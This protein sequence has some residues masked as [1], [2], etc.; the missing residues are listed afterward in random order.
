MLSGLLLGFG[1]GKCGFGTECSV[2]APES[3]FSKPAFYTKRGVPHSTFMMFRGLLPLQGFMVAIVVFNLFLMY[4]WTTG[5]G[6]MPNAV[7]EAGNAG[8]YWGH[9]LGAPLLAIGAVFMIGCEVRTYARLGLG[10]ATA[11]AALPGFYVGYLP[12]TLFKEQVD[13]AMFGEP[14][15][16]FITIPEYLAFTLGGNEVAWA[17][18]YSG[19]LIALLLYAF[20]VGWRFLG[21]SFGRLLRSNTDQLVFPKPLEA[22]ER[23]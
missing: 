17:W 1:I 10:Y 21:G 14:L 2:M 16:H 19:L 11:L 7:G 4:A 12:Y 22:G 8:L 3:V 18:G 5:I 6:V 15:T 23:A 13:E 9:I 20:G